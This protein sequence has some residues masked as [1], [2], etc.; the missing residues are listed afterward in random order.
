MTALI[1]AAAKMTNVVS[2]APVLSRTATLTGAAV[3]VRDYEGMALITQMVGVPTA[4][5]SPTWDG[6]V[7][8]SADGSTGWADVTGA[9]FTQVTSAAAVQAIAVDL[10]ACSR[11]I[12]VVGT[13]G[14]T[15]TPTYPAGYT[16]HAVKKVA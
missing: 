9:T 4:G 7:Q 15:S 5:S 2:L 12:R 10:N 16:M 1:N 13:L 3:D 11:Y 6:K 14:G 8:T